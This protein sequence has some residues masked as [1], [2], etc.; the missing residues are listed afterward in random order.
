[1]IYTHL[2]KYK[3]TFGMY[4]FNFIQPDTLQ[5]KIHASFVPLADNYIHVMY[6]T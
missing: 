5:L 3:T 2:Y 1:M 4:Y 6:K